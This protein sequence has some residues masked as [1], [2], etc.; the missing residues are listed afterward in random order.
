MNK[1]LLA[2]LIAAG[3]IATPVFAADPAPAAKSVPAM[4]IG[5]SI[6]AEA[7]VI[8]VDQKTRK[9][10]LKGEDGTTQEFTAGKEMRNLPQ[11]KAGDR[12]VV[13]YD[14]VLALRLKKGPGIRETEEREGAA[15]TALGEKPGAVAVKETHFVADVIN[16]NKKTGVVTIKGA[17]GRIVDLKIKDKA[18][19]A[20]IKVGDQVEGVYEQALALVVLPPAAA[21]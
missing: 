4:I 13:E 20:E 12:V 3:L 7:E 5:G 10:T 9:V 14:Q 2:A 21:K 16:V 1:I 8:A 17:K 6:K 11:V 18:V 15:R 19:V